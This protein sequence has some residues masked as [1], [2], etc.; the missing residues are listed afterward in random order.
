MSQVGHKHVH[1]DSPLGSPRPAWFFEATR[2]AKITSGASPKDAFQTW[3]GPP[4]L[5]VPGAF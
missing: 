4:G 5:A 1:T 2:T 3:G